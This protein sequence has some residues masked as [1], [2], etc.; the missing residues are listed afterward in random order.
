MNVLPCAMSVSSALPIVAHLI[1]RKPQHYF[2]YFL[3]D[4]TG[5]QRNAQLIIVYRFLKKQ[6]VSC[7]AEFVIFP[8]KMMWNPVCFRFSGPGLTLS[9]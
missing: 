5:V 8:F 4:E 2:S 6:G 9:L 7:H 1:L 3:D